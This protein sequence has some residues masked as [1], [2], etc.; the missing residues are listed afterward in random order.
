MQLVNTKAY[1]SLI[2]NNANQKCPDTKKMDKRTIHLL[3]AKDAKTTTKTTENDGKMSHGQEK[4]G[5]DT[6]AE[7]LACSD[8]LDA[9]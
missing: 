6:H 4:P 2:S 9:W 8:E 5:Q 7:S 1:S 3:L